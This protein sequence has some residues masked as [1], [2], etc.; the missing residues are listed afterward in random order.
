[1]LVPHTHTHKYLIFFM[2]FASIVVKATKHKKE[3]HILNL[4]LF[5]LKMIS[6]MEFIKI[7]I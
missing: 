4:L 5:Q 3:C 1:M 2:I 7:I 6:Y